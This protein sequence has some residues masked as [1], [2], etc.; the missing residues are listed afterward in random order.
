VGKPQSLLSESAG[1][2]QRNSPHRDPLFIIGVWFAPTKPLGYSTPILYR[3]IRQPG[4]IAHPGSMQ[5]CLA[6]DGWI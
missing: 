2:E 4:V 6:S 5:K 1:R 3:L